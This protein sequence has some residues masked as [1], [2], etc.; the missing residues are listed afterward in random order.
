MEKR[1]GTSLLVWIAL[2]TVYIVWGST[3]IGISVMD[4]TIPPFI[5][6][7]TRFLAVGLLLAAY[8]LVRRGLSALR[9][10][11]RE[12][13]SLGI[14]GTLL[15]AGGNGVLIYAQT[16]VPAGISAVVVASVPLWIVV[17]RLVGRD[18]PKLAT[19]GSTLFGFAGVALL[20][21]AHNG[22]DGATAGGLLLVVV[23]SVSW[24]LGSYLA[25]RLPMPSDALV[26][27][28]WEALLAGLVLFV[29]AVPELGSFDSGSVSIRSTTALAYLIT[30][31]S[32]LGLTA[33]VWLLQNAPISKVSTYAYVNPVVAILL[34]ALLLGESITPAILL[35][36]GI[37]VVAVAAVIMIEG[38]SPR[39]RGGEPVAPAPTSRPRSARA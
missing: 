16:W 38:R 29:A 13:L 17:L 11:R 21:L 30:F 1:L 24:A 34:G 19:V 33:Y 5:G 9:V 4:E 36:G 8:L 25:S 10:S 2:W 7:T 20:V 18:R 22:T 31:G 28:T 14:V 32:I 3:Y 12:L 37:I 23:A 6:A 39:A 35:G 26:S 15:L 27:T